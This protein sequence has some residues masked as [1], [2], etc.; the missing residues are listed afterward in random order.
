M[1]MYPTYAE[2]SA[3]GGW[4]TTCQR[5]P[6]PR[7]PSRALSTADALAHGYQPAKPTDHYD[8]Y[9]LVATSYSRGFRH[10]ASKAYYSV[11][12]K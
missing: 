4:T 5:S 10:R 9:T 11:W 2:A 6:L 3:A 1:T 7:P 8:E 12:G